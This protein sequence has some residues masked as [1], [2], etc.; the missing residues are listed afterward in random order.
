MTAQS[1][2]EDL[3]GSTTKRYAE[4]PSAF[5]AFR[6]GN[7]AEGDDDHVAVATTRARPIPRPTPTRVHEQVRVER[8]AVRSPPRCP[9]RARCETVTSRNATGRT[10]GR[11]ASR[12][13]SRRVAR[14]EGEER[15]GRSNG[16]GGEDGIEDARSERNARARG[17][18]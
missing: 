1:A 9:G 5:R 7:E 8:I 10:D 15:G 3:P 2:F 12:L 13:A 14:K 17:R 18:R 16:E 11:N 4:A 6:A